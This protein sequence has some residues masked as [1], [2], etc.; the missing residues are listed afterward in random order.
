MQLTC[1]PAA[2]ACL[3][4]KP[5]GFTFAVFAFYQP[6]VMPAEDYVNIRN[7]LQH[8][9]IF[10]RTQVADEKEQFDFLFLQSL[11]G[12][13]DR[14]NRP[15]KFQFF[16]VLRKIDV[17]CLRRNNTDYADLYPIDL[18]YYV[19]LGKTRIMIAP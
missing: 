5:F 19:W 4:Y 17:F 9:L 8:P 2:P 3:E 16:N 14:G 10:F 11:N 15:G 12:F 6:V 18:F 13:I 7:T 1:K